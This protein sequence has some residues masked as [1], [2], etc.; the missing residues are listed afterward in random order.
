VHAGGGMNVPAAGVGS[1]VGAATEQRT[2]NT[3]GV[4]CSC[5]SRS[6]SREHCQVS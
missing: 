2:E 1:R 6:R 4:C 3:E 5:R